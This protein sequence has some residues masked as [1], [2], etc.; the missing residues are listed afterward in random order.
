MNFYKL[1]SG[2][3]KRALHPE[4]LSG[5]SAI[6][7]SA[8]SERVDRVL[9]IR[10]LD[11]A[12]A[13]SVLLEPN[14]LRVAAQKVASSGLETRSRDSEPRNGRCRRISLFRTTN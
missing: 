8:R 3:D 7:S 9:R 1:I 12:A 14:R 4:R 5:G 2:N 13:L 10:L 11:A 6:E